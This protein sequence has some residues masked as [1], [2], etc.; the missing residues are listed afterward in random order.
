VTF[1][2]PIPPRLLWLGR[3]RFELSPAIAHPFASS[4][5]VTE[6]Y[7]V[8]LGVHHPQSPCRTEAIGETKGIPGDS[9]TTGPAHAIFSPTDALRLL[10]EVRE[11]GRLS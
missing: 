4:G 7:R 2:F 1:R 6:T 3:F 8:R 11:A 10:A 9:V 5:G